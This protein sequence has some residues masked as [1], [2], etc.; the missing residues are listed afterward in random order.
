MQCSGGST[1]LFIGE[2]E[3][4]GYGCN[5]NHKNEKQADAALHFFSSLQ[6]L[7]NMT[8]PK[9]AKENEKPKADDRMKM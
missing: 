9:I 4:P 7:L 2:V 6:A 5:Q 1:P 8:M 3:K